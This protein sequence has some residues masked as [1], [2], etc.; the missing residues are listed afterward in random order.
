MT[1]PLTAS[2]ISMAATLWLE[3]RGEPD[4]DAMAAVADT[5]M[6]R[7]AQRDLSP[8]G[9]V[10]EPHQYANG[11][12][13]LEYMEPADRAAYD[14]ARMVA[15]DAL[16]GRGLGLQADHFHNTTVMP[17]WARGREPV[18]RIGGHVFYMIGEGE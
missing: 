17:H 7:A 14:A 3:A 11:V 6:V 9:V 13:D 8:C 4:F 2:I 10:Q 5:I 1:D 15:R 16:M 12:V 18:A